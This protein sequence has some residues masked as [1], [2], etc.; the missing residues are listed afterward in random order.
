MQVI[1]KEKQRAHNSYFKNM[2]QHASHEYIAKA[3]VIHRSGYWNEKLERS[4]ANYKSSQ[5]NDAL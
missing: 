3:N 4:L 2:S 1:Q 5:N